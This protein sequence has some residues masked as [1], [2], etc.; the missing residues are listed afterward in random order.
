[1]N[2]THLAVTLY[3]F[4]R[5]AQNYFLDPFMWS[6]GDLVVRKPLFSCFGL[7][8]AN[9]LVK[10]FSIH[11]QKFTRITDNGIWQLILVCLLLSEASSA[12]TQ[13]TQNTRPHAVIR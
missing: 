10:H 13:N 6:L 4:T 9:L 5:L 3:F 2:F 8:V 7:F 1:V 12:K 11:S